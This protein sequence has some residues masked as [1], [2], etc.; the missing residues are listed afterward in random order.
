MK[1]FILLLLISLNIA[2]LKAQ[3]ADKELYLFD[4]FI[5]WKVNFKDGT[6]MSQKLNYNFYLEKLCLLDVQS[7]NIMIAQGLERVLNF[8]V[9]GRVLRID[10]KR[11]IETLSTA[12]LIEVSY[13]KG[14]RQVSNVGYGGTSETASVKTYIPLQDAWKRSESV[15]R[16][17]KVDEMRYIYFMEKGGEKQ[18]FRNSRQFLK[19]YPA[20]EAQ[21]KKYIKANSVKFTDTSKVLQLIR[22]AETL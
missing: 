22:Y 7:D 3:L 1:R 13:Q 16:N 8:E 14:V 2:G 11:L 20:H 18:E 9:D 4:D 12:P 10:G 5:D 15:M 6:S 17:L 19:L 21:L